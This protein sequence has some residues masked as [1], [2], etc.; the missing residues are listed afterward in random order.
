MNYYNRLINFYVFAIIC[1]V[2]LF[3][4]PFGDSDPFRLPKFLFWAVSF[5]IIMTVIII[6]RFRTKENFITIYQSKIYILLFIY[7]IVWIISTSLSVDKGIS[8]FGLSQYSGLLQLILCIGTF[9][10]V[11]NLFELKITHVKYVAIAYSIIS[12]YAILQ[13]Y[14]LDPFTNLYGP[15]MLIY[16][17]IIS[18]TIGNQNHLSTCLSVVFIILSFFYIVSVQNVNEMKL[19]LISSLI[20]FAGGLA[21][22]T[23]GGWLA[24]AVTMVIALPFILKNKTYRNRFMLLILSCFV[25]FL[26][27]DITSGSIILSRFLSIFSEVRSV[28][29]GDIGPELGSK[30]MEVWLNSID[31]I[32]QYWL[33]GSGPDTFALIYN[34]IDFIK[35]FGNAIVVNPHN[36]SLRL[37]ISSGIF[38]LIFYWLIVLIII[39]D[40]ISAIRKNTNVIPLLLGLI[41]YL[42]K[43]MFN[44][45]MVTDMMVFWVLLALIFRVAH[46][47]KSMQ[48]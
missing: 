28:T 36:E 42:V 33:I 26:V 23:R 1:I 12:V 8:T 15:S 27:M 25:I 30:R 48:P 18:S 47:T 39:K 31:L 41:C 6:I 45:S 5:F 29:N 16:K 7:L 34:D 46:K 44:C 17:D 3:F 22:K 37:L 43:C 20:I 4:L 19:F 10:L 40:G 11:S 32:K 35:P 9:I 24:I 2:P 21:T 38:S 14:N 13:F